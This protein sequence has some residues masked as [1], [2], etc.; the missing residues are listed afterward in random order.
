MARGLLHGIV[1][2]TASAHSPVPPPLT[3]VP[4]PPLPP[5][6]EDGGFSPLPRPPSTELGR[7]LPSSQH[8]GRR[9]AHS[10]SIVG[11]GSIVGSVASASLLSQVRATLCAFS[12]SAAPARCAPT[13]LPLEHAL[14]QLPGRPCPLALS[15]ARPHVLC[16]QPHSVAVSGSFAYVTA[17]DSNSLVV[18][19]ISNA[20]SPVI[21]GSVVSSSLLYGVRA[22]RS[23]GRGGLARRCMRPHRPSISRPRRLRLLPADALPHSYL[24]T[25]TC[26]AHR[27]RVSP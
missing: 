12:S 23:C 10:T 15:R 20:A 16:L 3:V 25:L 8:D 24:R 2:V 17:W 18:V 9:L 13:P 5:A 14:A 7:A 19:D 22:T 6:P 27:L 11:S 4:P 21:R 26:C 1:A